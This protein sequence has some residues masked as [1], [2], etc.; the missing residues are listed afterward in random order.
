MMPEMDGSEADTLLKN[1][2]QTKN[3][4]VISI[5][6]LVEKEENVDEVLRLARVSVGE[7]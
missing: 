3:T 1:N 2:Q 6:S 4:P 7:P 5:T